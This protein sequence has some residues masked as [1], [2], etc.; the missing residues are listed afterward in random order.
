MGDN[1]IHFFTQNMALSISF[2]I[3]LIAYIIF[4]VVSWL[5]GDSL[6]DKLK[7]SVNQLISLFNHNN[8]FII[9]VR[10]ADSY[11]VGHILD[12]VNILADSCNPEHPVIKSNRNR[13]I[14]IV[15][16]TGK[17]SSVLASHLHKNGIK[18][19]FYL[20]GGLEAWRLLDMPL[21][22]SNNKSNDHLGKIIIYTKPDCP[23]SVSAKNLLRNKGWHYKEIVINA[24]SPEFINMV[25]LSGGLQHTPQIFIN[26]KHIGDFDALKKVID[27]GGDLVGL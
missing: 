22:T 5:S 23:Y 26:N 21:V 17:R 1:I 2:A 24:D 13:P 7:I 9:D 15:C 3:A 10:N 14:I 11:Q 12:A 18:E 20:N 25:K 6:V 19:I 16:D 8:G 4:E 27:S